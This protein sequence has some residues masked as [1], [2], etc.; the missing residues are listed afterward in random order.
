VRLDLPAE[1]ARAAILAHYLEPLPSEAVDV[2]TLALLSRG[3]SGAELRQVV[4]EAY[5]RAVDRGGPGTP[6]V[7][8]DLVAAIRRGSRVETQDRPDLVAVRMERAAIH[9]AGHAVAATRLGLPVTAIRL[10]ES[11]HDGSTDLGREGRARTDSEIRATVIVAMAGSAAERLL[12]P[13]S[14]GSLGSR[15]D[16]RQATA[17]LIARIEAG[18]DPCYPPISRRAYVEY[19]ATPMDEAISEHV[20]ALLVEARERAE[21]IVAGE[22]E[23]VRRLADRLL[24]D[25]VLAGEALRSALIDAGAAP[26]DPTIHHEED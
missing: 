21:A 14:G 26:A 20:S 2:A 9:E 19:G 8:S 1:E 22:V 23:V 5:G 16:V 24:V 13:E 18:L 6:I 3:S 25:P 4:E 12:L 7:Q 15:D 11:G 17:L 10:G